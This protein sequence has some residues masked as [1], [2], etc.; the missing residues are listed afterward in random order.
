MAEQKGSNGVDHAGAMIWPCGCGI[1][2]GTTGWLG[3]VMECDTIGFWLATLVLTLV[4]LA[5]IRL[6]L[7]VGP[8]DTIERTVLTELIGVRIDF[9]LLTVV[10]VAQAL[11]DVLAVGDVLVGLLWVPRKRWLLVVGVAK[12]P[13]AGG[14]REGWTRFLAAAPGFVESSSP[15]LCSNFPRPLPRLGIQ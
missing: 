5:V 10:G 11:G 12:A 3:R 7:V 4:T 1:G 9:W 13:K 6:I 8:W 14:T 2:T 15:L